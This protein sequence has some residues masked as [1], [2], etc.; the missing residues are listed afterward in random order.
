M[1]VAQLEKE[2]REMNERLRIIA[3]RIDHVERAYR[4]EERPLLAQDYEEQQQLDRETHNVVQVQRKE[5]A[6][7]TH[8]EGLETKGRLKR[9]LSDYNGW[10]ETLI[11]K[12]G[13]AYQ[14]KMEAA[15]KKIEQEK[16]KRKAAVLKAWEEEKAIQAK[17][18]EERNARE[19]EVRKQEEG[20]F[21]LSPIFAFRIFI[22][23][24]RTSPSRR[25]RAQTQRRRRKTC[26]RRSCPQE[27][28]RGSGC[29]P[30]FARKGTSGSVGENTPPAAA[31]GGSRGAPAATSSGT[32]KGKGTIRKEDFRFRSWTS[33]YPCH[34]RS[35]NRLETKC[36]WSW[37]HKANR[38]FTK[39]R[40]SG[41][42]CSFGLHRN[43]E[44]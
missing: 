21:K 17:E 39:G 34:Q 10:K 19:E 36:I 44:I 30:C 32:R 38:K 25:R 35:R 6:K 31:R 43:T 26:R 12:K 33:T 18:E 13:E 7:T 22:L 5:A 15:T 4:K 28:G 29:A 41:A 16:A 3:K 14:K 24:N 20:T 1:Q 9:M 40:K 2:K 27:K 23:I 11:A 42:Y 8:Q 37:Y